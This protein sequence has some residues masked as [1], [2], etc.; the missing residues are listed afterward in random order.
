MPDILA[1]ALTM[2]EQQTKEWWDSIPPDKKILIS[3]FPDEL[4]GFKEAAAKK[5]GVPSDALVVV[6]WYDFP[7]DSEES[8]SRQNGFTINAYHASAL[9]DLA[10]DGKFNDFEEKINQLG[11]Y[12]LDSFVT[13][14]TD[15]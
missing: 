12:A 10:K 14:A 9:L 5:L 4:E 8:S 3:G 6:N 15:S 1:G 2:F 13:H 11:E 7:D